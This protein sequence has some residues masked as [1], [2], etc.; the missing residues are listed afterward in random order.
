[1]IRRLAL[2]ALGLGI[3]AFA[4]NST[5]DIPNDLD[6][7]SGT[8]PGR[9]GAK[10]A[11]NPDDSEASNEGEKVLTGGRA[12]S[13]PNSQPTSTDAGGATDPPPATDAGT[14]TTTPPP[15]TGACSGSANQSACFACCEQ[16]APGTLDKWNQFWDDCACAANRCGNACAQSWCAGFLPN[17]GDACDTCL[18]NVTAA[19]SNQAEAVCKMDATCAPLAV[20]DE[21]SGCATKPL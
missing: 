3:L 1:V 16:K 20:C 8:Y 7:K 18:N 4:C 15:T 2:A 13:Q 5:P 19:C 10:K 9:N 14:T 21:Q 12:P 11:D 6:S 17:Q